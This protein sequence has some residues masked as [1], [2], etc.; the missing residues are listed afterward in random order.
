[1]ALSPE[2]EPLQIEER[3][4]EFPEI[5]IAVE[6]KGVVTPTPTQFTA[7]VRD[8]KGRPLIQTPASQAVTIQL[9]SDKARL[10][11][12][13]KGTPDEAITWFATFWLRM[14][15]KAIL[16]GWRVIAKGGGS[17]SN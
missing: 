15:K 14:L 9:P 6:H 12:F 1:M 10:T 16:L 13:S 2:R 17:A 4:E 7:Q 8:D 11:A 3:P 5:P